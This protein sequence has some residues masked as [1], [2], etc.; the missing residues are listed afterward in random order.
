MSRR[1]RKTRRDERSELPPTR[2]RFLNDIDERNYVYKKACYWLYERCDRPRATYFAKRLEAFLSKD[3]DGSIMYQMYRAVIAENRKRYGVAKRFRSRAMDRIRR[4]I[5]ITPR[6]QMSTH[7]ALAK[8]LRS[9][10]RENCERL[11]SL[12]L[13][14]GERA[15]AAQVNRRAAELRSLV[16][17]AVSKT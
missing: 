1:K 14:L 15:D 3:M 8:A 4:S 10:I 9:L 13:R 12:H 17:S 7:P 6:Q 11:R 2:R 5:D 16:R